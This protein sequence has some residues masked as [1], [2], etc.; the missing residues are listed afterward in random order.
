MV[1]NGDVMRC[2]GMCTAVPIQIQQ[3]VFLVDF[4]ILPIQGVDMVLGVQWLQLLGSIVIDYQKLTMQ[5]NWDN[6]IISLQGERRD[7]Q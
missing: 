5:F 1:G 6:K 4:Y 3:K 2:K 7:S